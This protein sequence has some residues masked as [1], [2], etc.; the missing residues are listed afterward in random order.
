MRFLCVSNAFP[1]RFLCFSYAPRILLLCF[2]EAPPLLHPRLP[3][4]V[5]SASDSH[6][7]NVAGFAAAGRSFLR[8]AH[9]RTHRAQGAG[10][11]ATTPT[12]TRKGRTSVTGAAFG[13]LFWRKKNAKPKPRDLRRRPQCR[14]TPAALSASARH[15]GPLDRIV[16]RGLETVME[17][18]VMH[19]DDQGRDT[20]AY[21][22]GTPTIDGSHAADAV[23][24][25]D[26]RSSVSGT[27]HVAYRS[28]CSLRSLRSPRGLAVFQVYA[29]S[30]RACSAGWSWP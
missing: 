10:A 18:G 11:C 2:S 26:D 4:L 5:R 1:M 9:S 25:V 13:G 20:C 16:K 6:A 3:Y 27:V 29:A 8:R 19:G 21:A 28:L 15:A 23:T 24:V 22:Q 12:T 30:T 14:R 17:D 7:E